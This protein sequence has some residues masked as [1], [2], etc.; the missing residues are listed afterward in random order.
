MADLDWLPEAQ[1]EPERGEEAEGVGEPLMELLPLPLPELQPLPLGL[2]EGE[3]LPEELPQAEAE[4][5]LHREGDREPELQAERVG[6]TEL[7]AL[8]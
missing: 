5:L 2:P 6:V 4:L 3:V 8:L 7:E 1:P